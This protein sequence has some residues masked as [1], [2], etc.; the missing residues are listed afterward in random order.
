MDGNPSP[1]TP[2]KILVISNYRS[3]LSVRPEAEI[4]I[5]LARKGFDI[6]V[7]TYGDA[8]YTA[9]FRSAG[10]KVIDFHPERKFDRNASAFIRKHLKEGEYDILHMFNSKAYQNGLR[11]AKGLNVKVVMYRGTQAN[12]KWYDIG[13]YTKYYHPRTDK[14][15]CNSRSVEDEFRRQSLKKTSG[16]FVTVNKGHRPEW[17]ANIPAADL[18]EYK[19]GPDTFVLT[20]VANARRV[21]GVKYLLKAMSLIPKS[22]DIALLLIGRGLDTPAF[23]K[24]AEKSGHGS[25]IF[26]TGFKED[27]ASPVR[28][29]DAFVMPSIGAESLTKAVVEAMHLGTAPIITDIPGNKYLVEHGQ[30]GMVVPPKNPAA[31]AE[32]VK[33]LIQKRTWCA[34]LGRKAAERISEILHADRTIEEYAEFYRDLTHG[35]GDYTSSLRSL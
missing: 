27:A 31:L 13:M 8:P 20:C 2:P 26:F 25:R 3:T 24:S 35:S 34:D 15:V 7:M 10:I 4:F 17:Y 30:T 19:T 23:K 32:A 5:G 33:A 22:A 9:N 28:A 6:T 11:A 18:S 21:K 1:L 12:M 16:K 14:V 29:S